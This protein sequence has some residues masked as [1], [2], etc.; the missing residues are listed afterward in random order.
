M[1]NEI[2][3]TNT[4]ARDVTQDVSPFL[5][6]RAE[7]AADSQEH[8]PRVCE[9]RGTLYRDRKTG[10]RARLMAAR[11]E[12]R[13]SGP[14]RKKIEP[15]AQVLGVGP[16]EQGNDVGRW[17]VACLECANESAFEAVGQQPRE[18]FSKRKAT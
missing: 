3:K 5:K 12:S 9:E 13:C 16:D 4:N 10:V 6:N 18:F 2:H 1:S 15:G 11:Y 8:L 17:V 14:C 7:K